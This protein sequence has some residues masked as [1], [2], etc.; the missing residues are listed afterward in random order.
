MKG[1]ESIRSKISN[2][3][4]GPRQI[5]NWTYINLHEQSC[6][7]SIFHGATFG[8]ETHTAEIHDGRE[9]PF[10]LLQD[11]PQRMQCNYQQLHT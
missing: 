10:L 5:K 3:K 4:S 7:I 8:R 11:S 2:S 1:I 6:Y 9:C